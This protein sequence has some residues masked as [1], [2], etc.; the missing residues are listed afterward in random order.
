VEGGE[1]CQCFGTETR[2]TST[3]ERKF[4]ENLF[5]QEG[6]GYGGFPPSPTLRTTVLDQVS[7]PTHHR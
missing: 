6:L 2:R 5:R 1:D 3:L 4:E 7:D